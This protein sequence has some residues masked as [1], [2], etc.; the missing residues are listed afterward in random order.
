M[1]PLSDA[2]AKRRIAISFR[3]LE[4]LQPAARELVGFLQSKGAAAPAL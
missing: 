1:V 2:W 4:S 3:D